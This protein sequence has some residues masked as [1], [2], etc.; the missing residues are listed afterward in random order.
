MKKENALI[1]ILLSIIIYIIFL[2][3]CILPF[4]SSLYLKIIN[5]IFWSLL[6][7]Y[8]FF[9]FKDV[10]V[11]S[12]YNL[13]YSKIIFYISLVFISVVFFLGFFTGFKVVDFSHSFTSVFKNIY[14]FCIVILFEEYIRYYLLNSSKN[15]QNICKVSTLLFI[16]SDLILYYYLGTY[17]ML[18]HIVFSIVP[19]IIC[20]FLCLSLS[21]KRTLL[22]VYLVRFLPILVYITVPVVP[23]LKAL[24]VTVLEILY[25]IAVFYYSNKIGAQL[26]DYNHKIKI[27][28]RKVVKLIILSVVSVL[29]FFSIGMFD[30]VPYNVS[31]K[32]ISKTYKF[33]DTI[34]YEK[35][36]K[37]DELNVDDLVIYV[38]D[39]KIKAHYIEKI[40]NKEIIVRSDNE[41]VGTINF[42]DVIGTK[43]YHFKKVGYPVSM[44]KRIIDKEG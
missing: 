23:R 7:I 24:V 11:K 37:I 5:P 4:F 22:G 32:D 16:V 40:D 33:G 29:V 30:L 26:K 35:V 13:Y 19:I 17:S 18:K 10:K 1:S 28:K 8:T 36:E 3:I 15:L 27:R 44:I 12:K 20:N 31:N 41:V 14:F 34:I 2:F 6:F 38:N 42:K 21:S 39:G 25:F 43:K 9:S